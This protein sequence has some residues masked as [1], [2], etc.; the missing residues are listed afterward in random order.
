MDFVPWIHLKKWHKMPL[1]SLRCNHYVIGYLFDTNYMFAVFFGGGGDFS[2]A[3]GV[4]DWFSETAD[5]LTNGQTCNDAATLH[6]NTD[7]VKILSLP[8]CN[9]E[10]RCQG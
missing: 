6:F 1:Y 8:G 4:G 7:T 5:M 9:P 3:F 2:F 10:I